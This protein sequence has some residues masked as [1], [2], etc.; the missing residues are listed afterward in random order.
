[1]SDELK[2][3][4]EMR[5]ILDVNKD[6]EV[7]KQRIEELELCIDTIVKHIRTMFP[8]PRVTDGVFYVPINQ[9]NALVDE[10]NKHLQE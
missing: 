1:M 2:N 3:E 10:L 8:Y 5:H 6:I 4:M 9:Y 7:Q